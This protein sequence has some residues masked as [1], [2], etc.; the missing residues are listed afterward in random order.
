MTRHAARERKKASAWMQNFLSNWISA[1]GENVHVPDGKALKGSENI[2][3]SSLLIWFEC[4]ELNTIQK[5]EQAR[6]CLKIVS[7]IEPKILHQFHA[8][9]IL[10]K[11]FFSFGKFRHQNLSEKKQGNW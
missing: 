3:I 10:W 2:R 4:L 1:R 6:F 7:Q 9:S 11:I 5:R 8:C